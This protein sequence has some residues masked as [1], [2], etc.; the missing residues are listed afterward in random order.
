VVLPAFRRRGLYRA[1]V[2]SRLGY[3]AERGIPF[4]T[5]HARASTSAPLLER[6]G[7]ETVCEFQLF[8][9]E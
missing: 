9:N 2:A 4:V 3:A 1:L 8:S 5:S 6:L 7:F